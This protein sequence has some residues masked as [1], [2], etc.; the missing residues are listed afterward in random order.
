MRT[1]PLTL[2]AVF[3]LLL[4]ASST[5]PLLQIFGWGS[6]YFA[7]ATNQFYS[8]VADV[9]PKYHFFDSFTLRLLRPA[10]P[11][12][13]IFVLL[14]CGA[15]YA[16]SLLLSRSIFWKWRSFTLGLGVSLVIT[17]AVTTV[18]WTRIAH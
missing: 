11:S 7:A 5:I 15:A 18:L 9:N 8:P 13:L 4:I 14:Q 17:I 2:S 1:L 10:M 12:F 16:G 6:I 3:F